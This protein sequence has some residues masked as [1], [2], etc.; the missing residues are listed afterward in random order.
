[1]SFFGL[2]LYFARLKFS[3]SSPVALGRNMSNYTPP[4]FYGQAVKI[5]DDPSSQR[6][7]IRDDF[8]GKS[9]VYAWVNKI[10]KK[11][12]VGSGTLLYKRISNYY[13]PWTFTN[14]PHMLI[15]K[16]LLKYG[17]INFTLVILELS[18]T[19]DLLKCEQ[20]WMDKLKPQ[21][22]ISRTAGNSLGYRHTTEIK[23]KLKFLAL[24]RKH[25]EETR[26][27][28]SKSLMGRKPTTSIKIEVT[29]TNT[30]VTTLY[31]SQK[32]AAKDM[33]VDEK[34]LW[35]YKQKI[36][37]VKVKTENLYKNKFRIQ[38]F[39]DDS[40]PSSRGKKIRVE[41]TEITSNHTTV[42]TSLSQAA[43]G[44]GINEKTIARIEKTTLNQK[45]ENTNNNLF[46]DRFII[47]FNFNPT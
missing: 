19:K 15:L 42:Y 46:R 3:Y 20:K 35:H 36:K 11:V 17:M 47:K 37:Q 43:K 4:K 41:I 32:E 26:I 8:H 40:K 31:E 9:G 39:R 29:D 38:F 23:D 12:Y 34:T 6:Y 1:M 24:G 2:P 28:M 7:A 18:D 33:G 45:V 22:N 5:Y 14:S 25:S 16:A 21:Y 30:N 44:L 10:N 13:Q 27:K